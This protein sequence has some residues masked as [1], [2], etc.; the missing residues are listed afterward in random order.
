MSIK[1]LSDKIDQF[2]PP[3][4]DREVELYEMLLEVLELYQR[5]NKALVNVRS[6]LDNE[7]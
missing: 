4:T 5:T 1:H 3:K 6:W 7:L 2:G